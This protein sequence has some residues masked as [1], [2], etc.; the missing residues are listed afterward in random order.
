MGTAA[1]FLL[2]SIVIYRYLSLSIVIYRFGWGTPGPPKTGA[3]AKFMHEI[4]DS[5]SF[6]ELRIAGFQATAQFLHEI[7]DSSSFFELRIA[8]IQATVRFLPPQAPPNRLIL[9]LFYD[10]KPTLEIAL[11]GAPGAFPASSDLLPSL[12]CFALLG[13]P[14]AFATFR[15][16]FQIALLGAPGAFPASSACFH[17]PHIALS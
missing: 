17:L 6:F 11:L 4:A 15:A 9:V 13:A 2:L 14:G 10:S 5:S 8:R 3:T 1:S 16:C 7:T 12:L